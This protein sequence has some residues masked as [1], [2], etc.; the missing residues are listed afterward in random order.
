MSKS[1]FSIELQGF[2]SGQ[3]DF[4]A[5]LSTLPV[6]ILE[7]FAKLIDGTF[8]A[9]SDPSG[10]KFM[11]ISIV[12]H[13][14]RQ[15][16]PGMSNEQRRESERQ[17]SQDRAD[18]AS[19]WLLN[20]LADMQNPGDVIQLDWRSVS[21]IGAAVIASGAAQLIN[22]N[23]GSNEDLRVQNRRVQFF[24]TSINVNTLQEFDTNNISIG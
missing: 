14:D 15:D 22:P 5:Q 9:S 17:A 2:A 6:E 11:S 16:L 8:E 4:S 1:I 20:K 3:T 18:S 13:S 21:N 19:N 12:G 10:V 23:P 24:V 7:P